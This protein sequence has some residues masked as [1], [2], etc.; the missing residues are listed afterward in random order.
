MSS[1]FIETLAQMAQMSSGRVLLSLGPATA[2][3]QSSMVTSLDRGMTSSKEVDDQRRHLDVS[4][5]M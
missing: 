2:N 1:V 5:A 3:D 4:S